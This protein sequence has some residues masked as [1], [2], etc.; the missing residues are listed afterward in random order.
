[1][2]AAPP[3]VA[4][5]VDVAFLPIA[6]YPLFRVLKQSGNRRNLFL[7][8]LLALLAL[9]K[10]CYHAATL[11][12]VG[13]DPLTPVHAA[14]MLIVVIEIVTGGRVI[15]MAA[16]ADRPGTTMHPTIE[17]DPDRIA[18]MSQRGPRYTSYPTSDRFTPAFGAAGFAAAAQPGR[19]LSLYVHVPFC[20]SLCYYCVC[21][22]IVTRDGATAAR[23]LGYLM[24]EIDLQAALCA[25]GARV[26]Q[27]HFGGGTPTYLDDAQMGDL[28]AHL[29]SRYAFAPDDEGEYS[30]EID[31]RTVDARRIRTLRCQG[32]NRLSL[33]VQDF[34]DDSRR[35]SRAPPSPPRAPPA[36]ARSAST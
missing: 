9:A 16:K 17:F 11:A 20:E 8:V 32:F 22:K 24:R 19:S 18:R 35:H 14:I 36:S 6:A 1:M 4:A 13:A 34:D 7:V 12:W 30:I 28:L 2:L 29:R 3:I 5:A 23:Y 27:L 21:N 15:P 31:P 26:E 10:A 33:G 25:D